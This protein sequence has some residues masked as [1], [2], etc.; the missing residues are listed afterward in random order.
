MAKTSFTVPIVKDGTPPEP[1][2][3]VVSLGFPGSPMRSQVNVTPVGREGW[4]TMSKARIETVSAAS[5]ATVH[6]WNLINFIAGEQL[7]G[8]EKHPL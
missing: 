7:I 8:L 4:T 1:E 6:V 2:G 3:R 5:T